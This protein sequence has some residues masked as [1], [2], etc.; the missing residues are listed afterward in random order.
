MAIP[1]P[2]PSQEMLESVPH[3][4]HQ[5]ED[6]IGGAQLAN[7][8][9]M[10][11]IEKWKK[12]KED[13]TADITTTMQIIKALEDIQGSSSVAPEKGELKRGIKKPVAGIDPGNIKQKKRQARQ[14]EIA[15]RDVRELLLLIVFFKVGGS[16]RFRCATV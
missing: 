5:G 11:K 14:P 2:R 10:E 16:V 13:G 1:I 6:Q 4:D 3:P 15:G 7:D 9:L 12:Q 8:A